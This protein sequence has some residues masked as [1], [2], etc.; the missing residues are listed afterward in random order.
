MTAADADL[1]LAQAQLHAFAGLAERWPDQ[2]FRL[3]GALTLTC[4]FGW[5]FTV[6][7]AAGAT[8]ERSGQLWPMLVLVEKTSGQVVAT[9][10]PYTP[11]RLAQIFGRLLTSSRMNGRA[12]CLTMSAHLDGPAE[13]IAEDAQRAGVQLK[14]G[15]T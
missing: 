12:W 7:V 13:N 10:R 2:P 14:A 8:S 3:V 1:T 4:E 11:A 15:R 6:D 9:S 5:V